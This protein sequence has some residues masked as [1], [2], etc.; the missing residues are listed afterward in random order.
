MPMYFGAKP[1]LFEFAKRMR[2]APTE[3][4]RVMWK[5]L[6]SEEF[7]KYKFRR[8]HPMSKYIADF[9]SHPLLLV[10][11]LDGGYHL[12]PE[13]KEYDDFRDEDMSQLGVSIIR[14]TNDEVLQQQ[15]IIMGKLKS[16]IAQ[17]AKD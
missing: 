6:T 1:K 8:Q 7:I 5:F 4:E 2:Y 11:E 14:F 13:Q 9:F 3:A 16:H 12:R 15:E 10:I 17:I